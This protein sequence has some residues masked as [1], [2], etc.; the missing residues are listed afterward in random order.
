[1]SL[2]DEYMEFENIERKE[3]YIMKICFMCDLHLPSNKDALQYDVLK[4]AVEDVIK[5]RPD[6]IAYVG[7]VTCDGNKETYEFFIKTMK[8]TGI[9]FLYIPGNSDLRCSET[10]ESIYHNTSKCKNEIN[11][12]TIFAVNDS[13]SN[14]SDEQINE[15]NDAE[16]NSIVF[17][18]IPVTSHNKQTNL[19]L[20]QWRK[21]HDKVMIFHGHLHRSDVSENT[22]SLQAMD[23]D[24]SIGE[25]PCILYYDLESRQL[26]KA[27]Y[28]APVPTDIYDS[29]G[30]SCY[31]PT[32]QINYAIDNGLKHIELRPNCV[33]EYGI[34]ELRKSVKCW[35]DNGG[36]SLSIHLSDIGWANGNITASVKHDELIEVVKVLKADRI[37]QHVP[38]VSV[39]E[40]RENP[41]ILTAICDFL[42]EKLNTIEHNI[43]IGIENMH[44]TAKDK[45]DETRRFGY[46][47]EECIEFMELLASKCK[48]TVGINFD[49]GHA[50]NNI[51]YSQKYQ[52][53][54]WLSMIGKYAVGYHIHQ[55]NYEDGIFENHMPITDI[56]G[57]LI[58][59]ASFF[60][61][62]STGRI[63]KV[64]VIFEMRPENAYDITLKT[65]NK[66]KKKKV[67]DIHSHTYYSDCGRD[68]PDDLIKTAIQNGIS[69]FGICDHNY[70]I[71]ERKAEYLKEMRDMA[72]IYK[73]KIKLLC[74]IEIA[75]LPHLYDI[76]GYEDIK[77]FDYCL[78]EHLTDERSI[79]KENIFEFCDNLG[80][81][82]GVA[83]T[84]LFQYCDMYGF[85]YKDFF[86]RMAK[87]NIFWE[88]NVTYDS[89]HRY[90]EHQYVL[91]FMKDKKK[92]NIIKETGV[93]VSIGLDSHR[94]E[95][96]DGYK[97]HQMYDFLS[98]NGIKMI[99]ELLI[100]K[101]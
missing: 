81:L 36:E 41:E 37:T 79:V 22:V 84:D 71:G 94:C 20:S 64:P 100:K 12:V 31:R 46:I 10:K 58:S 16:E 43:V 11:G 101:Q 5:K 6:C 85:E 72:D 99:D 35:R 26:R 78:I 50:R 76:K 61:C 70:G 95:D 25:N 55:V 1:M 18:H 82:C 86:T 63:N 90:N 39:K 51:P 32:E 28:F 80:I 74:G 42:A 77:N 88:M 73:D 91:E 96:Y 98:E 21:T 34:E 87:N 59:Y 48:H 83:H 4:W 93:Y 13:D 44:M 60:R 9:P 7:D 3:V 27:Y 15:L 53:S 17:M 54:T 33:G 97:V 92:Q 67:F 56:Y 19:K 24:K 40:V 47:P 29:L 30:I 8:D 68:N 75:T 65:F 69:V 45:P 23:P 2:R 62:W 52:I 14:I 89:I 38:L 57:H 66:Y 49:I